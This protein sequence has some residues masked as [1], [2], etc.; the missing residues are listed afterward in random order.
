MTTYDLAD[1]IRQV[2]SQAAVTR[3]P[4]GIALLAEVERLTAERDADYAETE[5]LFA[6]SAFDSDRRVLASGRVQALMGA[7]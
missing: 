6:E 1:R 3:G 7:A 5:E 4:E 2:R